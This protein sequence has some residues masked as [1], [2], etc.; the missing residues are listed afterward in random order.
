MQAHVQYF[1]GLYSIDKVHQYHIWCSTFVLD[2]INL[3]RVGILFK[4]LADYL[5]L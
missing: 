5:R 2:I 4:M 1:V 3:W